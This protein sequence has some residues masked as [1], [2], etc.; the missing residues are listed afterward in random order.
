MKTLRITTTVRIILIFTLGTIGGRGLAQR[1]MPEVLDTGT[2]QE[3][4]NYLEERTRIYNDFRAI[5]EDMF[6]KIKTNTN[7][8]LIIEKNNVLQLEGTIQVQDNTIDSLQ[9]VLQ[10]TNQKLDLAIKNR[11]R[12]T[13]LGIPLHKILYNTIM[14]IAI[15]ILAFT[16]VILLLSNKRVLSNAKRNKKDLEEIREEFDTYRKETRERQEQLVVKH[17]NELRKL[18]GK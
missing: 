5:R 17:H 3:Q 2:I 16:T 7:D 6:Q 8:T 12:M 1:S 4:L 15:A 11:D 13:F 9:V 10:A 18:K 14:W